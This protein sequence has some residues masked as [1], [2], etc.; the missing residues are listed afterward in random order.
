MPPQWNRDARISAD[1]NAASVLP[2]PML[3]STIIRLGSVIVWAIRMA[4]RCTG[5]KRAPGM[6]NCSPN[7][8]SGSRIIS[9]GFQGF[10]SPS[11]FHARAARRCGLKRVSSRLSEDGTFSGHNLLSLAIQSAMMTNAVNRIC[12]LLRNGR[13]CS[14]CRI[15][16]DSVT[17]ATQSS[18]SNRT[19]CHA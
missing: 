1:S 4:S 3:A 8:V 2:S 14:S 18:I 7:N 13:S 16:T 15:G 11:M 17:S 10:G 5:R 12:V 9:A 6:S 19:S